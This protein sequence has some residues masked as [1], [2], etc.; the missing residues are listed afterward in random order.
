MKFIKTLLLCLS[1]IIL[2]AASDS[3]VENIYQ[4]NQ[5]WKEK[6]S[7]VYKLNLFIKQPQGKK[8]AALSATGFSIYSGQEDGAFYSLV[9]TNDH[10]CREINDSSFLALEDVE[11]NFINVFY[12]FSVFE[13]VKTDSSYDL[14]VIKV[15]GY[16]EPIEILDDS[17]NIVMGDEVYVIGAPGGDFPIILEGMISGEI[18]LPQGNFALFSLQNNLKLVSLRIMKGHSGSPVLTP[19]GKA[20]GIIFAA[21]PYYGGLLISHWDIRQFLIEN[22]IQFN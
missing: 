22:G 8:I 13:I 11:H 10:F 17:K 5:G 12:G 15:P 4:N 18:A 6:Y 3:K 16:S 20:A 21:Y 7:S 14:C 2:S 1:I 19:D 9:L